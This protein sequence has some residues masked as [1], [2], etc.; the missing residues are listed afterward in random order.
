MGNRHGGN[1]HLLASPVPRPG[2]QAAWA[3]SASERVKV[4]HLDC[5]R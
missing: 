2:A 4:L 1:K 5:G 3:L